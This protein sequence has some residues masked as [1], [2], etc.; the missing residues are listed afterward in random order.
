MSR[1][2]FF[3]APL[4]DIGKVGITDQVLLKPG[5]LTP[6][7]TLTMRRHTVIG[8]ETLQ[9]VLRIY[10]NNQFIKM[11]M[12]IACS[13]H[14][15]WDGSGYPNGLSGDAIPLSARI[16]A[17]ADQYDALRNARPY[18]PPYE[19]QKTVD[20]ITVGDGRT[21]PEHFDPAVLQAFR[22]T[23]A[24]LDDMFKSFLSTTVSVPNIYNC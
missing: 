22:E 14:E 16:L 5:E 9:E 8:S 2:F 15:R 10:P 12:G 13:H 6:S 7:E 24:E 1:I 23:S 4:H 20:I 3:T 11:G 18:K 17:V 19:H 21:M